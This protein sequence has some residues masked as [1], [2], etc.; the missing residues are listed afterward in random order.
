MKLLV[1]SVFDSKAAVFGQPIFVNTRGAAIRSFSDAVNKPDSPLARHAADYSLYQI[2]EYDDGTGEL[3][4]VKPDPVVT[5]SS[6]L[7]A[8]PKVVN[9]PPEVVDGLK[10]R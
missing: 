9:A 5:A 4:G 1:F 6:V 7:I 2:G 10:V 8:V 3:E